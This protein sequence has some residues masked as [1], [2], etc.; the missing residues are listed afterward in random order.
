ML[1]CGGGWQ[2]LFLVVVCDGGLRWKLAVIVGGD[3]WKCWFVAVV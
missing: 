3:G 1:I 2:L